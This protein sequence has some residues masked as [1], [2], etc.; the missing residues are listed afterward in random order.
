MRKR[1]SLSR[2]LTYALLIVGSL[3][4][5]APVEN[6]NIKYSDGW[7]YA[8]QVNAVARFDGPGMHVEGSVGNT[9]FKEASALVAVLKSRD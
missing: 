2:F 1:F 3:L 7:P 6:A 5:V 8:R 9:A 4:A